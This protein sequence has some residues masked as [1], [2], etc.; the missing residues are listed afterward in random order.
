MVPLQV[1]GGKPVGST[2]TVIVPGAIPLEGETLTQLP[3]QAD[4]LTLVVNPTGAW[5]VVRNSVCAAGALV[6]VWCA[7]VSC[8]GVIL[9][10]V[11]TPTLTCT[12]MIRPVVF[13]GLIAIAPK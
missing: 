1:S 12:G 4:V 13:G 8:W 7:N 10:A 6:P 2:C 9:I 3:T 5:V 11:G